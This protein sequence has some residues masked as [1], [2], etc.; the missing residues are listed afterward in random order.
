MPCHAMPCHVTAMPCHAMP[1][2]AVPKPC[3]AQ[4]FPF[5]CLSPCSRLWACSKLRGLLGA[6]PK[7]RLV[8]IQPSGS[9]LAEVASLL[10]RRATHLPR[11]ARAFPLERA[12]WAGAL[13]REKQ[14]RG[15][16][17][18]AM[19]GQ[20]LP[21]AGDPPHSLPACSTNCPVMPTST[22]RAAMPLEN[23]C[24][25]CPAPPED[26]VAAAA[27]APIADAAQAGAT[28]AVLVAMHMCLRPNKL[29][30]RAVGGKPGNRHGHGCASA[31]RPRAE[32]HASRSLALPPLN[33]G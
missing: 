29:Y 18:G 30:R 17:H 15:G 28:C 24:S 26:A 1:W 5:S 8:I 12:R 22:L 33:C 21:P 4:A 19:N 7:L 14:G 23:L 11:I 31:A 9:Q 20:A 13:G 10:G 2:R 3:R 25:R 32:R 6:G 27:G 16:Q